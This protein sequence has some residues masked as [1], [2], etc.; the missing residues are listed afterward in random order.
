MA[1]EPRPA[2]FFGRTVCSSIANAKMNWRPESDD[3]A[4]ALAYNK[5][6]YKQLTQDFDRLSVRRRQLLQSFVELCRQGQTHLVV[7]TTPLHPDLADYL[8]QTTCYEDRRREL[9]DWLED[10]ARKQN[11]EFRDLSQVDSFAGEP[12]VFVDGVHPLE[13]NTRR[14]IDCLLHSPEGRLAHAVQ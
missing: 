8:R 9:V 5:R 12:E 11:F 3:F 2:N 7:F 1:I 13:A 10:L 14:M 4:A 6:E